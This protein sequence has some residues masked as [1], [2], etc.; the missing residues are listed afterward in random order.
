M[1]LKTVLIFSLAILLSAAC[2]NAPTNTINSANANNSANTANIAPNA[3]ELAAAKSDYDKQK[4]SVCH[5]ENGEGGKDIMYGDI[6]IENVP[7]FKNPKV[8]AE[9]DAKYVRKIENGDSR[10]GMPAYKDKLSADEI[11]GLVKY[12]RR[13][14]QGK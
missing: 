5:K 1:K 9:P 6:K 14:F 7:S 4:C 3:D 2:T 13:E 8:I 12:I 11:N 10:E